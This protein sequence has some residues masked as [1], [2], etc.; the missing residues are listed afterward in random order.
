MANPVRILKFLNHFFIGGTERQFIHIANGLDRSRFAVEIACLQREGP[1][2]DSLHHELPLHTYPVKGSLYSWPSIRSRFRLIK[3][4]RKLKFDIVHTYGWYPNVFA[5]PASRVAS[6]P[7]IIASIRDTGA[8]MTPAKIQALKFACSLADCV[9]ANSSAGR[10][11]LIEQGV[12]ERKIEIIRNGIVVPPRVGERPQ[13]VG[14][15]REFGIPMGTPVCACIGRVVSGKG[16][17][18]YLRA[19]RIV[20][21][22]R[23]DVR[24]LMIGARSVEGNYQ[25][26]LE[27]LARE[28]N[29]EHRVIFTGQRHDVPE[30]LREVDIVVHP[31]LT[32]GLSNVILE[33]MAAGI[34]VIATRVGGNPELVEDG[35]TGYLVSVGDAGQI[36]NAICRLLEQPHMARAFGETARQ[37]VIDEFAMNRMLSRTED[38]YLR[39]LEERLAGAARNRVH[40]GH[41]EG[42]PFVN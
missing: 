35:G 17:D 28:L 9:L 18:C 23:P 6:C 21:D 29:L 36:A 3:D 32:E 4:V 7:A 41:H 16:I 2:L 10:N 30:I 25:P 11:W 42:N 20:A 8:Y 33:A 24:F 37:R 13:P 12:K 15:H 26:Q 22:R 27:L 19:A 39:V 34:P 40:C 1:L 5:I 14:V 38:L 31:S